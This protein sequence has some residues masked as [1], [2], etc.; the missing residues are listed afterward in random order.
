[1]KLKCVNEQEFVVGG[2]TEPKGSRDF[3]GALLVG[4]H[5]GGK[6]LF[7]SKVGTGYTQASLRELFNRFKPL[8]RD[9]CPFANLPTRRTGKFGQGVT[10]AEMRRC[11]WLEPKLVAQVRFTEWTSDGGLRHPVFLGLRADKAPAE[12]VREMPADSPAR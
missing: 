11:T 12:V 3:F 10:A 7:A 8:R 2:Y 4:Y 6:L 9:A 5:E 1:L